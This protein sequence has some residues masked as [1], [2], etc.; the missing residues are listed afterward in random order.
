MIV[1]NPLDVSDYLK[2]TCS[3]L[4]GSTVNTFG[5]DPSSKRLDTSQTGIGVP[6][7][8]VWHSKDSPATLSV[9]LITSHPNGISDFKKNQ[10]KTHEHDLF[11]P[12]KIHGY[13]AFVNVD[14]EDKS[15][16]DCD[17]MTGVNDHI[18]LDAAV[19]GTTKGQP[20]EGAQKVAEAAIETIKKGA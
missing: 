10:T 15:H 1:S 14:D 18:M 5:G 13:P 3:L 6:S 19:Q 16:G 2:H 11:E 4:P 9:A 12:V 7:S 20:C 8:C 17:V